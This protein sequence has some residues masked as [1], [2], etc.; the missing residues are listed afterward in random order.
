MLMQFYANVWA[1]PVEG[2]PYGVSV[3][4]PR[5]YQS[6][7]F[8]NNTGC[9]DLFPQMLNQMLGGGECLPKFSTVWSMHTTV[10]CR[11]TG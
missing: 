8:C 3:Y 2:G 6:N 1:S 4:M 5:I 11:L 7:P 9:E 10:Q